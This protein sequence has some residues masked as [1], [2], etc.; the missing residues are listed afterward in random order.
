MSFLTPLYLAGLAAVALPILFHMI[1][2]T[3]K[4]KVPFSTLMFLESSPP[5][6]T[7]RSK[8]EHWL[9]LLLRAVAVML[10]VA[11]FSRPFLREHQ[12][13]TVNADS[14]RRAILL[15]VSAS[16]RRDGLW[17]DAVAKAEAV[18]DE[19]D[20]DDSLALFVFDRE[21]LALLQFDEW[22]GLDARARKE[23]LKK[24]LAELEPG[25]MGTDLGTIL[26]EAVTAVLDQDAEESSARATEVILISDLQRGSR[27]ET[28]QAYEWP[29]QV[30]LKLKTVEGGSHENAGLTV[31]GTPDADAMFR[32]RIDNSDESSVDRFQVFAEPYETG[33]AS[34][35]TGESLF[36]QEILVPPDQSRVVKIGTPE[37]QQAVR[38]TLGGDRDGFDNEAWLVT[39]EPAR[40]TIEYYGEG[41]I[42]DPG[43]LRYYV[44]RAFLPTPTR[45]I[46]FV[47]ADDGA[48]FVSD[49]TDSVLTVVAGL[50]DQERIDQVSETVKA[51]RRVLCV[52]ET[53]D[54]CKQ[55]FP[56][57]GKQVPEIE[58]A[59]VD[60][61]AMLAEIDFE[62]PLFSAFND[63][64]LSD[65]SKL[66]I[67]RHR[68]ITE[69]PGRTLATFDGG[70]PAVVELTH[71][72]GSVLLFAFGWHEEESQLVLSSRFVPML[73][74]LL[75]R[76]DGTAPPSARLTVGDSLPLDSLVTSGSGKLK[77]T[78]P[79]GLEQEVESGESMLT[80][81]P[82]IYRVSYP[83]STGPRT[84]L[85]AVNLD[86]IESRTS[87]LGNDE[88]K[89]LGLPLEENDEAE[90]TLEETR[91]LKSREL[92][93]RQG[94]WQWLIV[95][96][97]GILLL[98]TWLAGRTT[99]ALAEES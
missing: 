92:E 16:M 71:G 83:S 8:I 60:G 76:M 59:A 88:L 40:V 31:V 90:A 30:T 22:D 1:R 67:F 74:S 35:T 64:S 15:D 2:R 45:A 44:Q 81:E 29:N 46:D 6:V 48:G 17:K 86:P 97:I 42:D 20:H 9:L 26:P 85:F 50:L 93:S 7:R 69:A 84:S 38:V 66:P 39:S 61:Y 89:S 34:G 75:D 70:D 53:I 3:P 94:Y 55:A 57:A 10:L 65:F 87:A 56:L 32:V 33:S 28:L 37:E 11:A 77:V 62:H 72:K 99:A 73:N 95:A 68:T 47:T 13:Q 98:E 82:G 36:S 91:Q 78:S 58:E 18:I 25:W 63:V 41:E 96:A 80:Q 27:F 21:L 43:R 24:D 19:A 12:E 54:Q 5:R 23:L 14:V 52:G 4:G 51:G 79:A 49:Q